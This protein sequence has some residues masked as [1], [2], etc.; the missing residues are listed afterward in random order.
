MSVLAV[1]NVIDGVL[2]DPIAALGK[3]GD[4]VGFVGPDVPIDV[5]LA[6]RRPFGHL[7]WRATG[8]TE[9]ADRWLESSFPFWARSILE[10][11]HEG[12]F[13]TLET[14]V[15]SRADDASQRLYYYVRE[16]QRRG[17]LAGPL[18]HV[19]DI[20]LLPRESSVA[21]TTAAIG[22]LGRML[23]VEPEQLNEGIERANRLR[24]A[25]ENIARR[26]SSE[27]PLH[28]RLTRVTLFSDPS[29]WLD[30]MTSTRNDDGDDVHEDEN[31]DKLQAQT[32]AKARRQHQDHR[33]DRRQGQV[34]VQDQHKDQAQNEIAD[35]RA[36]ARRVLLAG[37]VPPDERLHRATEQAGA[38]IVAEAH[39]YSLDRLGPLL[40][41]G[42][43]PAE[44]TLAEH[45]MQ[46]SRGPRAVFD[47]AQR[48]LAQ[49]RHARADAVVL[50]LTREDEALAWHV[51]AQQRA[52][53]AAGIP[54]LVLTAARWS[55]DD[56]ALERIAE[57]CM[58]TFDATP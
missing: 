36:A 5:L 13:D 27:G 11:W 14:V 20:A 30:A 25:F 2:A 35:A 31:R 51:P 24:T 6:S 52:L 33:Q 17:R 4:G 57:F 9:W 19:F 49:A 28:E 16:L 38:C 3:A 34:R 43:E 53:A 41:L 23:G 44:R 54:T 15:F 29:R 1:Q 10:Q 26:R 32:Q 47:R 22:K 12:A 46:A 37:S 55:A 40:S 7:P 56:G 8:E 50:W 48:I 39:M 58:E 45:L 18:P 42:L 21:H